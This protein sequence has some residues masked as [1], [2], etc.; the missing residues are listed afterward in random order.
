MYETI[1]LDKDTININSFISVS[2]NI[3]ESINKQ[4][5]ESTELT[6]DDR[7]KLLSQTNEAFSFFTQLKQSYLDGNVNTTES[8]INEFQIK[9]NEI[10]QF[11]NDKSIQIDEDFQNKLNEYDIAIQQKFEEIN[12][13]FSQLENF[14]GDS[15]TYEDF[16]PEQIEALKVKGDKGDSFTYEDFTPEQIELLK[17]VNP[18]SFYTKEDTNT[19]I[20]S[21]AD[22]TLLA[23]K[24][25]KETVNQ[26]LATL[27][28]DNIN[29]DTL[30]EI[31]SYISINRDTLQNLSFDS[32]AEGT[33]YK[34]LTVELYSKTVS[35]RTNSETDLLLSNKANATGS[36]DKTFKGANAQ[37][38]TEFTPLS[39]VQ[40]L[41]SQITID[42]DSIINKPEAS[43]NPVSTILY[44]ATQTIPSGYLHCNGAEI[45]RIDY[46]N[47]FSAIGTIYGDGN[48]TDTFN[49]P[50]LRGQFIRGLDSEKGIDVN[51]QLG[52]LQED[53]NK[54]HNH[55]GTTNTAGAHTHSTNIYAYGENASGYSEEAY[56]SRSNTVINTSSSGNHS[57]TLT[58]NS[59]GGTESRP[60]NIAL[61]PIIKY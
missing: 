31:V 19:L 42:Y 38:P 60:K 28:S 8:L 34:K 47:L 45:S 51:R 23:Q 7:T 56:I 40:Q 18:D 29:L 53:D 61:I 37:L 10:T 35:L 39:Q 26:I 33:L 50:D 44:I 24:A 1:E 27:Q 22:I 59:S 17:V 4:L 3:L 48:G 43:S 25:D 11:F 16:T 46:T 5:I 13:T 9:L 2:A 21:K 12:T 41:I 30:Q 58:I 6:L 32:I 15:F 55:S 49:L 52:T 57:H 54:S 36:I 20:D 14:K